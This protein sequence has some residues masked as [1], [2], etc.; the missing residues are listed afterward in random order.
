MLARNSRS[1][2]DYLEMLVTE[3]NNAYHHF[4]V[5]KPFCADYFILTK[6]LK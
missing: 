4:N 1:Y 6:K 5:K 2:F 3:Y